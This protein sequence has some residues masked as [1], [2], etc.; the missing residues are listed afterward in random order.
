[1]KKLIIAV[2]AAA[3]ALAPVV[4]EGTTPAAGSFGITAS[5]TSDLYTIGC[6]YNINDVFAVRPFV[7]FFSTSKSYADFDDAEYTNGA[8]SI[9]TD[10]LYEL[11]MSDSFLLG[12]GG[13]V[14]FTKS[15]NSSDD[16]VTEITN[17]S[18][19]FAIAALASAQ[20]FLRPNFA[21]YTDITFGMNS[22]TNKYD[23]DTDTDSEKNYTTTTWGTTSY[24]LGLAYYIK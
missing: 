3:I 19:T 10:A 12:L 20:Y 18:T 23:D 4:A 5:V 13:K 1:M 2:I 21:V 24:S 7:G 8:F 11:K 16:G 14:A 22:T 9:G 6:V 15:G 17:D